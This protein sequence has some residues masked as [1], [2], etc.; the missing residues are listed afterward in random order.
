[1]IK[2]AYQ[3]ISAL[4][5][6]LTVSLLL[7]ILMFTLVQVLLRYVF[8]TSIVWI[9]ELTPFLHIWLV[10]LIAVKTPQLKITFLLDKMPGTLKKWVVIFHLLI[11]A[12]ILLIFVYGAWGMMQLTANDRFI[13]MPLSI[14]F[15]YLAPLVTSLVTL[16][17]LGL[18]VYHHKD[19]TKWVS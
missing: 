9:E 12:G 15:L 10:L 3:L 2:K 13:S 16:V 19:K 6:I 17:L 5:H 7:S 4:V 14:K 1:M 11:K 18:Y 8:S